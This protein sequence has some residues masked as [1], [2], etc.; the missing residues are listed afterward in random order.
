MGCTW[1]MHPNIEMQI[2]MSICKKFNWSCPLVSE[3]VSRVLSCAHSMHAQPG[4]VPV[5]AVKQYL[6]LRGHFLWNL[7]WKCNG[8][9]VYTTKLMYDT[10]ITNVYI[11]IILRIRYKSCICFLKSKNHKCPCEESSIPI[12]IKFY[13]VTLQFCR[14]WMRVFLDCKTV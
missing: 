11:K 13:R 12:W 2:S 7:V 4:R 9:V 3:L 6:S 5:R 8:G 1:E 14:I 10:Q